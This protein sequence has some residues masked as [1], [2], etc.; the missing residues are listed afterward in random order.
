M[1][2][3]SCH[4][5]Y[6]HGIALIQKSNWEYLTFTRLSTTCSCKQSP[7]LPDFC[8]HQKEAVCRDCFDAVYGSS[9]GAIN[10]TYFLAGQRHGVDVYSQDI[11]TTK[12]IDLKRLLKS[13]DKER[14]EFL[15][16]GNQAFLLP[17][18]D[19]HT[20]RLLVLVVSQNFAFILSRFSSL[21]CHIEIILDYSSTVSKTLYMQ[22]LPWTWTSS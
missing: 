9:A 5:S 7:R 8:E 4:V 3:K 14:S 15:K 10:S 20:A 21:R 16:L 2:I 17:Y 11:T 19:M 12:F 22:S 6:Q 1:Q 13:K 18:C